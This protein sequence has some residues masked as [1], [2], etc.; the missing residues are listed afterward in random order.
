MNPID[1][2]VQFG[3]YLLNLPPGMAISMLAAS[4]IF[5]SVAAIIVWARG[6]MISGRMFA[7]PFALWGIAS[8]ALFLFNVFSWQWL[9]WVFVICA[10][11][12]MVMGLIVLIMILIQVFKR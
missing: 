6:L 3:N 11:L 9:S 2:V 1:P 8:F 5:G 4:Q 7:S 10:I 12:S